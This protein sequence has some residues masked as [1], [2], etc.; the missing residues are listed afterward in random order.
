MERFDGDEN[1]VGHM[2]WSSQLN[3]YKRFNNSVSD[4]VVF[5]AAVWF[6]D[7]EH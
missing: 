5:P 1:D 2:L 7:E 4:N 6:D 3:T